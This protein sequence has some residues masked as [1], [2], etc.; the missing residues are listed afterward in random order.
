MFA[1]DKNN[2]NKNN[3]NKD[4]IN[5]TNTSFLNNGAPDTGTPLFALST[6]FEGPAVGVGKASVRGG[7]LSPPH[8]RLLHTP[9]MF[10]QPH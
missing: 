10:P 2:I 7:A 5:F 8:A 6:T 4:N 1:I 3:I 9:C